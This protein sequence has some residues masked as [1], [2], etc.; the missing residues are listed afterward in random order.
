M[1]RFICIAFALSLAACGAPDPCASIMGACISARVEGNIKGL[2]QLEFT[3]GMRT[4]RTPTPPR[5][6]ELPVMVA[7]VPPP[8]ADGDF[9]ISVAG[10]TNGM[11]RARDEHIVPITPGRK[12]S[13]VFV[14]NGTNPNDDLAGT[15][16]DLTP[17]P[18]FAGCVPN[19]PCGPTVFGMQDD[20]CGTTLDCGRPFITEVT[21]RHVATG[22]Q[23]TIHGRFPGP[24]SAILFPGGTAAT[25]D[26][27]ELTRILVTVPAGALPG[28]VKMSFGALDLFSPPV[29][30]ATFAYG[31]QPFFPYYDQTGYARV[32]QGM[33]TARADFTS[34]IHDGFVY[35]F[36]GQ[37]MATALDTVERALINADGTLFRFFSQAQT[38]TSK[39]ARAAIAHVGDRVFLLGGEDGSGPLASVES[40]TIQQDHSIA[41]F[42]QSAGGLVQARAGAASAIIGNW[43][44]VFGGNGLKSVERAPI[45]GDGTLGAF[46]DAGIQLTEPR[47]GATAVVLGKHLYVMGGVGTSGQTGTID[48]ALIDANGN[49]TT[50][51]AGVFNANTVTMA[52]RAF[53]TVSTMGNKVFVVGG[54]D[55]GGRLAAIQSAQFDGEGVL[56]TFATLATV[57]DQPRSGAN[58]LVVHNRLYMLGGA[59]TAGLQSGFELASI[60]ATGASLG[61]PTV[62]SGVTVPSTRIDYCMLVHGQ[63]VYLFGG[64]FGGRTIEHAPISPDGAVGTFNDLAGAMLSTNEHAYCGTVVAGPYVY[65]V[66]GNYAAVNNTTFE[67]IVLNEDGTLGTISAPQAGAHS[68]GTGAFAITSAKIS[69]FT[70]GG[71]YYDGAASMQKTYNGYGYDYAQNG[72]GS[73]GPTNFQGS[74]FSAVP[75]QVR[76]ATFGLHP[77]IVGGGVVG[78]QYFDFTPASGTLSSSASAGPSLVTV[79]NQ[80]AL[81]Y[82]GNRLY[83]I[84]GFNMSVAQNTVEY[85]TVPAT[86]VLT[87]GAQSAAGFFGASGYSN[88]HAAALG[89]NVW[90]FG[91]VEGTNSVSKVQRIP[92]Q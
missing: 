13:V 5:T 22:Q 26:A 58:A 35:V 51:T 7:L 11:V 74:G 91:G 65:V 34:A 33:Q 15:E 6:F 73:I 24:P 61:T 28:R 90:L 86:G 63:H 71:E 44:Y 32:A 52:A 29:R 45:R 14:L 46:A 88:M 27:S 85:L 81:A 68:A 19:D 67:K 16:V 92:I 36:G 70:F 4:D 59:A 60:M 79:R 1:L 31:L 30:R 20:G 21:P 43:V 40:T 18:D 39:R 48:E 56:Q 49:L 87:S 41:A 80:P 84:G 25:P 54:E 17:P 62:V 89:N 72:D 53:H 55:S 83:V 66:G 9:P 23:I 77:W 12:T 50:S 76:G 42:V 57:M 38:M 75:T 2:D 3:A 69:I 37:G 78:T 82:I 64:R 10:L 8:M 47:Y